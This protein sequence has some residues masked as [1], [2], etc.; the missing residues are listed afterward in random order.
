MRKAAPSASS[1]A[2]RLLLMFVKLL[3]TPIRVRVF[4]L[5]LDKISSLAYNNYVFD[6]A[7][8]D[9]GEPEIPAFGEVTITTSSSYQ[10]ARYNCRSGYELQGKDVRT[11]YGRDWEG[12]QPICKIS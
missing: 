9:C 10:E 4:Q 12:E 8:S 3:S 7:V 1:T 11:C 5:T 6:I 2:A